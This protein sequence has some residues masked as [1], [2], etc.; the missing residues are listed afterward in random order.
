MI[1]LAQL[2]K[3]L[4][5]PHEYE[6]LEFKEAKTQFDEV[7]TQ[8]YCCAL[9]NEGGGYLIFGISDKLPRKIVGSKAFS[10]PNELNNLKKNLTDKL[11]IRVDITTLSHPDGRILILSVPPRPQG[12]PIALNGAYYMRSGQSLTPMTPDKLKRIFSEG[13]KNWLCKLAKTNITAD[14]VIALLDTQGYFDLLKQPYPTNRNAVLEKLASKELI[15]KENSGWS[16]TNLAAITLAKKLEDFSAALARKAPRFILYDGKSKVSTRDEITGEKGYAVGFNGLVNFVHSS[17]PKNQFVEEAI[18]EEVKMFPKQAIRELIANALIHQDFQE[19]G[20]T[21]LIEMY[22]DRLEITNP[23]IPPIRIERFIDENKS[24]NEQLADLMRKLHIC[25]AK[26]S[27]IDKVVEAVELFQLPAPDFQVSD[28]H[29]KSI[30]FAHQDFS[31][32]RKSDRIRACYQHCCL[33]YVT[34]QRMSNLSLKNRFGLSE[35]KS[36]TVSLVIGEAKSK[37][38]IKSDESDSSSTRYARYLPSWA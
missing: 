21:I 30:L 26:G 18:R 6:Q 24:R 1:D 7:K 12:Q 8:K 34:G 16:I 23:G 13:E 17:A 9:A 19:T 33:L 35:S 3:W 10:R 31:R 28:L 29:T 22:D 25:E 14:E 15:K 20:S 2:E 27:G 11:G 5:A 4:L 32:M 37:G 36:A 38:L